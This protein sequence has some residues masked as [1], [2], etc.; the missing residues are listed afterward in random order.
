[1]YNA[2]C[3]HFLKARAHDQGLEP[4]LSLSKIAKRLEPSSPEPRI[5][6]TTTKRSVRLRLAGALLLA[7]LQIRFHACLES[8]NLVNSY[9]GDFELSLSCPATM[10]VLEDNDS[11]LSNFEVLSFL[12]EQRTHVAQSKIRNTGEELE[13]T[14]SAVYFQSLHSPPAIAN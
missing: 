3:Q 5:R 1:V 4:F 14:S 6:S 9:R 2:L 12:R 7:S 11:V 8:P 13:G 10:E